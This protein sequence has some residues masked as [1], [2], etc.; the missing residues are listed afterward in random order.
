MWG[1][2]RLSSYQVVTNYCFIC[3]KYMGERV[4][5]EWVVVPPWPTY[6]CPRVLWVVDDCVN[7]IHKPNISFCEASTTKLHSHIQVCSF[8]VLIYGK[9]S[10]KAFLRF[11]S[12]WCLHNW[13]SILFMVLHRTHMPPSNQWMKS[14]YSWEQST[15][16][17]LMVF[18]SNILLV[19]IF[20]FVHAQN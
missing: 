2:Q 16:N 5:R 10:S 8:K 19:G 11:I 7:Q 1:A 20:F 17:S 12:W 4:S 18:V 15:C 13:L 6:Y 9:E 3:I 14:L